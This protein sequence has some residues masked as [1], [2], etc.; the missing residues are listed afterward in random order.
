MANVCSKKRE[1]PAVND[2]EALAAAYSLYSEIFNARA[3]RAFLLVEISNPTEPYKHIFK[4]VLKK[5][6]KEKNMRNKYAKC[7]EMLENVAAMTYKLTF[8]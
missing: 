6:L 7:N 4:I 5:L 8:E 1:L 2:K 3:V